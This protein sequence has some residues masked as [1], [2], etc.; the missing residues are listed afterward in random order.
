MELRLKWKYRQGFRQHSVQ[1]A[2]SRGGRSDG[3]GIYAIRKLP[4]FRT[5]LAGNGQRRP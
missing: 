5:L 4:L 3:A 2:S 1:L